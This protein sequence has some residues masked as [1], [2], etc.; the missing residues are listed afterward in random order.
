MQWLA[1]PR[2]YL[3]L[4]YASSSS[5]PTAYV[6]DTENYWGVNDR[7]AILNAAA[8]DAYFVA[9]ASLLPTHTGNTETLLA[10]ALK[11]ASVAVRWLPTLGTLLCCAAGRVH[12]TPAAPVDCASIFGSTT[13][14]AHPQ[15]FTICVKYIY[16]A[17]A[18]VQNA[19]GLKRG[20]AHLELCSSRRAGACGRQI[21]ARTS[22]RADAGRLR[23][24]EPVIAWRAQWLGNQTDWYRWVDPAPW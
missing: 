23:A 8:A 18:A 24:P 14:S 20:T 9:R 15:G 22:L 13:S 10:A 12:A 17:Q 16:E 6:P 2:A 7:F 21:R 1:D 11:A 5:T 3:P 4:V 19:E